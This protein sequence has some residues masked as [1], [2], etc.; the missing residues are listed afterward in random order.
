MDMF[1]AK[2]PLEH[3]RLLVNNLAKDKATKYTEGTFHVDSIDGLLFCPIHAT[4][5]LIIFESLWWTSSLKLSH[6][7]LK[8]ELKAKKL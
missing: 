2:T 3:L 1:V 7:T 8:G 6:V 4:W 5:W